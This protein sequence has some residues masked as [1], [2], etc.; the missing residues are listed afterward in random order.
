[1]KRFS[2]QLMNQW[3][4]LKVDENGVSLI[5][6]IVA[7]MFL[8]L[9]G[10]VTVSM[11]VVDSKSGAAYLQSTRAFW[12]AESGIELGA[13]WLRYEIPPPG[14]KEPFVQY[15]ALQAGLGSF[16]V[17]IDPDD[18]NPA[19]YLKKYKIIS[20]G[21]VDNFSRKLE[22]E[23]EMTTF[24]KYI[25]V[26]ADEGNSVWFN[27]GDVLEGPV[28]SNDLIFIKNNPVFMGKVTSSANSFNQGP[29]YAYNPDFQKGYQ[30]GVPEV[31]FPTE[32]EALNSYWATNT[33]TPLL[34]IDATGNK[35]AEIKFNSDGTLTYN[36]WKYKNKRKKK[37]I[38]YKKN[39][40]MNIGDLG[41]LI[42]IDGNVSIEGV[43]KG[44]VTIFST[45]DMNLIDDVVYACSDNAG[46]PSDDCADMLGL[47]SS[48]GIEVRDTEANRDNIIINAAMLALDQ[49]FFV[50]GYYR[51][52]PRGDLTIWGSLSQKQRGV[53]GTHGN[54]KTGY[55]KDYHFDTRFSSSK[56]PYYPGTGQYHFNYWKEF[57]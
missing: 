42:Y 28:H 13:R 26:T 37:K 5:M 2:A 21:T 17:T 19:T 32:E 18:G 47:I 31:I 55:Y 45:G 40:Q 4:K 25:Y 52:A 23:M 30:L 54:F 51:G 44:S 7:G 49:S 11:V 27:T 57:D 16:T 9:I 24:S 43:L 22:V 8:S 1:M 35:Y 33:E 20:V 38:Y 36:L 14:G 15:D 39:V 53:V 46:K 12:L 6:A 56:P 50:E 41:G 3:E 10:Y 29:A 48:K 34:T